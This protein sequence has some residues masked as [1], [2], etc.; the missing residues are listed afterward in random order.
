[1]PRKTVTLQLETDSDFESTIYD[2]VGQLLSGIESNE[3]FT[4]KDVKIV[5]TPTISIIPTRKEDVGRG[6]SDAIRRSGYSYRS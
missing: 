1:M 4:I 2:E 6:L 3:V 5:D